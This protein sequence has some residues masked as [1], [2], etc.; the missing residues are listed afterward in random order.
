MHLGAYIGAVNENLVNNRRLCSLWP[1]AGIV[2][3]VQAAL[4]FGRSANSA[5]TKG[6]LKC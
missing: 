6:S 2:I 5:W 3:S 1:K 4:N